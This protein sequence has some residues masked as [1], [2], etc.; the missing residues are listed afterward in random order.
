M[1]FRRRLRDRPPSPTAG[2]PPVS[3]AR[4]DVASYH[5]LRWLDIVRPSRAEIDYLRQNFSFHP[6]DLDDCL[7]RIQVPKIDEYEDYLFIVLHFPVQRDRRPITSAEVDIFIGEDFL[8]TVHNGELERLNA[9]YRECRDNEPARAT[10]MGRSSGYLLYQVLDRLV[11][12]CFPLLDRIIAHVDGVEER[13]FEEAAAGTVRALS[14]L[15]RDII[16]YRRIVKPQMAVMASLEQRDFPFLKED[17]DVY[18]GDLADHFSKIWDTLEDYKDVVEGLNDTNNTLTSY[19]INEIIRVL[20][21]FSAIMLP[22]SV[23]TGL[24]GMNVALPLGDHPLAFEIV[25][26]G[27]ATVIAAM[28]LVFRLRRWI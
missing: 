3:P 25:A 16:T 1:L 9:F 2:A 24:Y 11:D 28:L 26:I 20:T 21:L 4:V 13:I 18:F 19:R 10:H 27:M 14:A 23:L 17:L 22:L 12:D 7:S 6:L 15:R 8:I 5:R